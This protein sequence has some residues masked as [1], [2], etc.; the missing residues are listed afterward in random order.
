M[1]RLLSQRRRLDVG[2]G[3]KLAP[4]FRG[5]DVRDTGGEDDQRERRE[6]GRERHEHCNGNPHVD[7]T[8]VVRC[9]PLGRSRRL[10]R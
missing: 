6:Q 5:L 4:D 9:P 2:A 1:R 7:F 8:S 10:T 3:A